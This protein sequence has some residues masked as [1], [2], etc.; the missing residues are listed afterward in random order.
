MSP[1]RVV[2]VSFHLD[3]ER[4][5]AELLL[6]AWPTLSAVA[7]AAAAAGCDVTVVQ[8][9]HR[10]ETV[11]RG[12][13]AFRFVG[14]AGRVH[15]QVIRRVALLRP[16][17]VHVQ[18]FVAA[19]WMQALARAL[20]GVP[21][22][23]Q[24]HGSV[25]PT[26]WRRWA[27]RL[28]YGCLAGVAF[29]ARDQALPWKRAKILREDLPVFEVLEGSSAFTPGDRDTARRATGMFGDPCLFWTG[30][31][32]ANKD[33]MT[34]L[35]AFEQAALRLPDA[36]LWCCYGEAPL[37][38]AVQ[39]RVA[40]SRVLADRVVLLGTRPHDELEHRYRAADFFV[41]ASHRE[42]S[43]YS[44]LE[45]MACGVTPLVTDIPAARAIVDAAGSLTPVGDPDALGDAIVAWSSRDGASLRSAARARF[46][47]ALTFETI[48]RQLRHAYESLA[49]GV[50][51][52]GAAR[53]ARAPLSHAPLRHT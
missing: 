32:D 13:V 17:V 36:R 53:V 41:Q 15:S 38:S 14:D 7:I 2:H 22:L 25:P 46:D 33:P 29:T 31:L 48:G 39:R 9:A 10:T 8:S 49:S 28:A 12:G 50:P 1:L 26:G 23:V 35:S 6:A 24:D 18:G 11:E 45:A 16:D 52:A 37:L 44:L 5:G 42:G 51:D 30:R 40:A 27:A 3:A 34:M 47:E 4:R 43:G 20:P 21:L 19:R